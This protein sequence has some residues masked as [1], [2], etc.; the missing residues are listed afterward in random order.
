MEQRGGGPRLQLWNL[1][2]PEWKTAAWLGGLLVVG[3]ILL[4][5]RPAG[6]PTKASTASAPE[7]P[8]VRADP[9]AAE[10]SAMAQD[11]AAALG[12]VAGAGDVTVRVRLASGPTTVY[13]SND[14]DTESTTSE[15]SSGGGLQTTV[16]RS[17]SHQLAGTTGSVPPVVTV[18]APQ[19]QSVLV[20][21][22]GASSPLVQMRLAAA[23]QAATGIP[24][25]RITVLPAGGGTGDGR[26]T[27]GA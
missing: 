9:L 6:A 18:Q 11:L 26:A 15:T 20:V 25:F 23:A 21:A 16:Q 19:I 13:V 1:K 7:A 22:T 12:R 14:Q 2:A 10:E 27:S 17:T 4:T 3:L 5:A 8:T 24:L